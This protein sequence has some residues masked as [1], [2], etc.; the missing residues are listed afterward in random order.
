MSSRNQPIIEPTRL[1]RL[2]N[3]SRIGRPAYDDTSTRLASH[4]KLS[5]ANAEIPAEADSTKP[6]R[7]VDTAPNVTE[8]AQKTADAAP[9]ATTAA[10][11]PRLFDAMTLDV[12]FSIPDDLVLKGQGLKASTGGTALGDVLVTVGG[13]V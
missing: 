1:D 12:K 13:D 11:T 5:P 3:C 9:A 2:L 10:A 7:A 6:G 4:P 8:V